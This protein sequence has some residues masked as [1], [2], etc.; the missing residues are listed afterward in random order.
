[1]YEG[2]R[3]KLLGGI[4]SM[5]VDNLACVKVKEGVSE[6]FRVDSGVR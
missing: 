1:M 4:E 2:E 6:R 3:G 5:Y